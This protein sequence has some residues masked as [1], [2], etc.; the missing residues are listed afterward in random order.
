MTAQDPSAWPDA[1]EGEVCPICSTPLKVPFKDISA[2]IICMRRKCERIVR[3]AL[4][5]AKP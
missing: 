2:Y 1:L 5:A 4:K 3:R